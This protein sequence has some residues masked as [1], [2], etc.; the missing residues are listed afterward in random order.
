MVQTMTSTPRS[1]LFA[2]ALLAVGLL[3]AFAAT[4]VAANGGDIHIT[5]E[6]GEGDACENTYCYDVTA[7]DLADVTAGASVELTLENPD[8]NGAQH[9]VHVADAADVTEG[10]DNDA[11]DAFASSED[12]A[13]GDST[14]ISFTV[15]DSADD[16][17]IW[18]EIPGHETGGMWV[19]SQQS[20]GGD[21]G[22]DGGTNGSPGFGALATI[23][24]AGGA[25][26][27]TR[28]R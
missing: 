24:A 22:G 12:V 7:G 8:K 2:S 28:R 14:T 10:D 5:L 27:L 15:P 6:A 11:E 13:P 3:A 17:Y 25:L 19:T 16:I 4:P 20:S 18:C 1:P 23:A 9:N 26:A 21:G